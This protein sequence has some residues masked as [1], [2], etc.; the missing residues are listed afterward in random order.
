MNQPETM[1][2]MHSQPFALPGDTQLS[3][4][5][6]T[7]LLVEDEALVREAMCE[8]LVWAGFR[9]LKGGN[10]AEARGVFRRCRGAVNLLLA[11]VV[12]PDQNGNDLAKELRTICP[13]LKTILI[14]GY[15]EN[16]VTRQSSMEAGMFY[17]PKPFTTDSLVHKVRLALAEQI[18]DI[19]I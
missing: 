2:E 5:R 4:G 18:T 12:L 9:V 16:A 11:D 8:A 13:E 3:E 10:A 17:L 7:I 6:A 1:S 14:S 19:A 15:P